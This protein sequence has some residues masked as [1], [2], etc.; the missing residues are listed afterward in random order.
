MTVYGFTLFDTAIGRCGIAWG[1][2]GIAGLQLPERSDHE[3]RTCLLRKCPDAGEAS[4]PPDVRRVIDGVVALL[5]GEAIDLTAVVLDMAR[6][7][8]FERR[9]YEVARTIPPGSTLTYG[10]IATRLGDRG[11]ARDVGQALGRNPFPIVVPCHRV[12][13][14]AGKAGG[15]SASGGLTTKLR[16]LTIERARTS[17]APT[18]FDGDGTFGLAVRPRRRRTR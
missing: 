10:D 1:A 11:L 3:T 6:V 16:M 15:F 13:A 17:E 18:L 4:P 9:V 12:L 7:P 5:R 8:D 2:H 14:A